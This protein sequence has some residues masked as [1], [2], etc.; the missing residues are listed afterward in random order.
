MA[1]TVD[2]ADHSQVAE[3]YGAGALTIVTN[4]EYEIRIA[5]SKLSS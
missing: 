1:R 4:G 3:D 5:R 2:A